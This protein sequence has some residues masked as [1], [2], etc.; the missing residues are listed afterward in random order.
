MI[1]KSDGETWQEYLFDGGEVNDDEE[2]N[3]E[4]ARAMES[5]VREAL[6][7][8]DDVEACRY[9]LSVTAER[10]SVTVWADG[11][12]MEMAEAS[13]LRDALRDE[14]IG[15]E[16]VAVLCNSRKRDEPGPNPLPDDIPRGV[17]VKTWGV[18]ERGDEMVKRIARGLG[19][20]VEQSET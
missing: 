6:R 19:A 16:S 9:R 1:E 5:E 4:F 14:G 11:W 3:A 13:R 17:E 15:D 18:V 2:R 10:G 7:T 8:S 12:E 20:A